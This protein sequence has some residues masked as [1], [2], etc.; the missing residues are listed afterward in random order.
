MSKKSLFPPLSGSDTFEDKENSAPG[1]ERSGTRG[2]GHRDR[3]DL[4]NGDDATN[5]LQRYSGTAAG[6][7]SSATAA[8]ESSPSSVAELAVL[9]MTH[10]AC[11]P[12]CSQASIAPRHPTQACTTGHGQASAHPSPPHPNHTQCTTP[13]I[14]QCQH[15]YRN[16]GRCT[17]DLDRV[18]SAAP[19]GPVNTGPESTLWTCYGTT[20]NNNP[21]HQRLQ[22]SQGQ[23]PRANLLHSFQCFTD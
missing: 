21:D 23:M 7:E 15:L 2:T 20:T 16:G 12:T 4:V 14:T 8:T 17:G 3:R 22:V 18:P 13:G 5:A 10:S 1:G 6:D 19:R 9:S 11:L